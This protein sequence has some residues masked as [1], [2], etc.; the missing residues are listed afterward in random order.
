MV[1][2]IGR[3]NTLFSLSHKEKKEIHDTVQPRCIRNLTGFRRRAKISPS[4][5]SIPPISSHQ[6][7]RLPAVTYARSNLVS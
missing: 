2:S 3:I 7:C 1:T 4:R 5:R 6:A